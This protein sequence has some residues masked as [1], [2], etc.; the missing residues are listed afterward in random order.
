MSEESSAF[1]KK[2]YKVVAHNCK[3]ARGIAGLTLREA[4]KAIW[5]Y[6]ND[7]MFPN[8]MSELESGNKKIELKTVYRL[9][10][11]YGCSPEFIF[12][13]SD[14]FERGN[15]AAKHAGAVFQSVRSSV[16]EATEQ[17][18]MN[19]SKSITHLPPFQGEMLKNSA[20]KVVDVFETH[21]HDL[22]F[23]SQYGDV[24]EVVADLKKNVVMFELFF[25]KQ[26]RQMELS[27]MSMLEDGADET[28]SM[29]L[30]QHI[31]TRK[32]EKV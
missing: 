5:N 30:T 1:D 14:E 31:E 26:M 27:M 12:G 10:E 15:L 32:P 7:Q 17:L 13:F 22:V 20:R 2:L 19:V 18:C 28:A 6:N 9:C 24:L 4:Q 23:K 8:R 29:K 21:S 16:L 3:L 11:V 25:A